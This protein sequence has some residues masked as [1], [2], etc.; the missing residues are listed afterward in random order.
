MA[1]EKL[2]SRE[3]MDPD[4]LWDL[5]SMYPSDK[6]HYQDLKA[7]EGDLEDLAD[8]QG[9]LGDSADSLAAGIKTLLDLNRRV[10]NVYV[11]SHLKN[12]QDTGNADYQKLEAEASQVYAK[13]GQAAAFFRP[14]LLAIPEETLA[15]FIEENEDLQLASHFIDDITRLRD[16][17]LGSEEEAL[18]ALA[19]E[20]L[21]SSSR[22]FSLLD[23]ADLEFPAVKDSQGKEVELS[24]GSYSRLIESTDRQ[25]RKQAFENLHGVYDQFK[26]T[27]A[28]TLSGEVKKNNFIA[29]ARKYDS[30]RQASLAANAVPEDVYDTLLE[31][32]GDRV[33]LLHDYVALRKDLLGLEDLEMYD[34]YTPILGEAPLQFSYEEAQEVTLKALAPLGED[35]LDIMAQA[36]RDKWIDVYENKGKRSGAYSSGSYDSKPYILMN[37]NDNLSSLYTLVHELGHSAH[38]YLTH[39]NQEYIYGGYPIFLAEIASTTNESLLTSYLLDQ[40]EDRNIRLYILNN[41][42]DMVKGTVFRQTQFAEFEHFIYQQDGQGVPL[43]A[44]FLSDQYRQLNQKYYGEAVNSNSGIALEWSR[45]PHFYYNYYVFQYA[46]GLS[47]ATAL[48][49]GILTGDASRREA[50]LDFLKSGNSKYPIETM[51][52]AGVDMTQRA[53]IDATLDLFASRLQE[54]KELLDQ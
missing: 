37:W 53:Y 13:F 4:Y 42:L 10:E 5:T 21:D 15:R 19:S 49:E 38:S 50:Y 6:A 24:H 35:Y 27:L 8:F 3:E 31:A 20:A 7:V 30:A 22:T 34:L 46:T 51:Q 12:D 52:R 41:F 9:R 1:D 26:N 45:I 48:A 11:Y 25:V 44:D 23:N 14:E 43:T 36:F 47:A 16:H 28:S 40:Y 17:V 18:L 33:N 54:F 29:K 32:V 2:V 39:A